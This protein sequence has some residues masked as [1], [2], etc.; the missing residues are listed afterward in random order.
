MQLLLLWFVLVYGLALLTAHTIY[1][2]LIT[3]GK[4][5]RER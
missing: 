2:I 5:I 3:Q 1:Y 4:T